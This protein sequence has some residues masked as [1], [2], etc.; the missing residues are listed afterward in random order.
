MTIIMMKLIDYVNIVN[1]R[2]IAEKKC[3]SVNMLVMHT[4]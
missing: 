4:L 2:I 3:F 1:Y